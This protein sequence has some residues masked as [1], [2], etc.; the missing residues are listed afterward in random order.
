MKKFEIQARG[1][2]RVALIELIEFMRISVKFFAIL[3]DKAGVADLLFDLPEGTRA[4]DAIDRIAQL[5]PAIASL[6]PHVAIAI[7]RAYA[8]RDTPLA[9]NDELALIPP[10]S[11]G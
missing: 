3:K 8:P 5:H 4:S 11:G 6:L 10:V 1:N 7:N 2:A 9:D